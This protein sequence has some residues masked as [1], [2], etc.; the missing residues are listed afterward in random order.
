[1][2]VEPPPDENVVVVEF[3]R[4]ELEYVL[5]SYLIAI[6]LIPLRDRVVIVFKPDEIGI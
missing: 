4:I 1:V 5:Y 6:R 2:L 3:R